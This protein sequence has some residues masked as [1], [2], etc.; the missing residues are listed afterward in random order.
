MWLTVHFHSLPTCTVIK[1]HP[2]ITIYSP[3]HR[4]ICITYS[5]SP[6]LIPLHSYVCIYMQ[7]YIHIHTP[8]P[9][10]CLLT[11]IYAYPHSRATH[12]LVICID[13]HTIYIQS[14]LSLHPRSSIFPDNNPFCTLRTQLKSWQG[15]GFL[16]YSP[17]PS[18]RSLNTKCPMQYSGPVPA[19]R[20][21]PSANVALQRPPWPV[22]LGQL[23][24][25][26]AM[27]SPPWNPR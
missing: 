10:I 3:A 8:I 25:T 24:S 22:G 5:H 7:T 26:V 20:L 18:L 23:P 16:A 21:R 14:K 11:P 9:F 15:D 1:P 17:G 4:H 12:I 6:I 19:R 2:L 13:I 27:N